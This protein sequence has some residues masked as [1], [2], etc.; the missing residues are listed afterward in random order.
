[1][2]NKAFDKI[3]RRLNLK[4]LAIFGFCFLLL[5]LIVLLSKDFILLGGEGNYY[6]NTLFTKDIYN[7]SWITLSK[8]TG[9]ANP[10]IHY[11]FVIFDLFY[12]LQYAGFSLKVINIISIFL[13][14][15]LPF[16]SMI[17]L[18]N[19]VLK[20]NF[21]V[22]FMLSLFY[23]LNPFSAYH[24]QGMMFWNSSPLFLLPLAF[25]V[26]YRFYFNWSNLFITFGILT[27]FLSFTL[28]NV[29]YLGL[30]H[31]FLVFSII[32]IHFLHQE[33]SK[34]PT[35]RLMILN[36]FI[37]ETSFIL[38]NSWWLI[39]L[40]RIQ[41]QDI[42]S[43]YTKEFAVDWASTT[44]GFND[45]VKRIFSLKMMT[46]W[47]KGFFFSDYFNSAILSV[48][49]F[50]PFFL[51]IY[52]F[53]KNKYH[54]NLN[55]SKKNYLLFVF[56]LLVFFLNKGINR[57]FENVYIWM[58][59][60]VPFFLIFKTPFE[61]WSVLLLFLVTLSLV[62]VFKKQWH[63]YLF[64]LYLVACSIPYLTL[65]FIPDFSFQSNKYISRKYLP[66]ESYFKARE[67]LN[68]DKL[69]SRILS[70][71]GSLNY[72]VT[73]LNHDKNKYYRGMDPFV[74]SVNKS[75]VT[76][77][78]DP[79]NPNLNALF[80]NISNTRITDALFRFF[81]IKDIVI[82]KN[83]Y[84]A[85]GFREN[86]K[87]IKLTEI[88]EKNK[89]Q[90]LDAV[91][92]YEK[93]D[94]LPRFYTPEK[95]IVTDENLGDLTKIATEDNSV[96]RLAV[97]FS[98]Q[99]TNKDL[100][101]L[102]DAT[103]EN[104]VLEFKKISPVKYRV[105]IHHAEGKFPLIFS[106]SFHKG[107]KM[108]FVKNKTTIQNKS[109]TGYKILDGNNYGQATSQELRK[110]VNQNLI[111]DLGSR[112]EREIKHLKW[113]SSNIWLGNEKLDYVEKYNIDFVSKNFHGTIQNDNL[114][115]GQFYETLIDNPI[116]N[117]NHLIAN[118]YANSWI[119]DTD[120]ICFKPGYCRKN[121]DG[122][123]DIETV[124]EF[125]PQRLVYIGMSISGTTLLVSIIYLIFRLL[126]FRRR[127]KS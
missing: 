5:S 61:K 20:V 63:Y 124:V 88:F 120:E 39:N 118:S 109:L 28:A 67:L 122:S 50:I 31:I 107:W 60:N 121:S 2:I 53:I 56:V 15:S 9:A 55:E 119:V 27:A 70:L 111:S 6:I 86:I 41:V 114:P 24:L 108:Y 23:I 103:A 83:I 117:N 81:N 95:I 87:V 82:D 51:L 98:K 57:P 78:A 89:K 19:R 69:D 104:E 90:E 116:E 102:T 13:L 37:L 22:S 17:W 126:F 3:K 46:P 14:Y 40:I 54:A 101:S 94:F 96:K 11:P 32:I 125:S 66:K 49:S 72:Q 68:N 33:K 73:V 30:F 43:F 26:I 36:I 45:I 92:V 59:N 64:I 84:P 65:N 58:L 7:F 106:E 91:S 77:Y 110:F 8:S 79:R 35:Y 113:N 112:E 16:I 29:P 25:G 74:Y 52:S 100:S 21:T 105:I 80:N 42:A 44:I 76:A 99:N 1:M 4:I 62:S 12:W 47:N 93:E 97:F 48:I 85:F 127:S 123:Y 71:P 38:F 10:L 18:L 75:F 115:P 34:H